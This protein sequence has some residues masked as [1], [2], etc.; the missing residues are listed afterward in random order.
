MLNFTQQ[1]Y[2]EGSR[3]DFLEQLKRGAYDD[4]VGLYRSNESAKLVTGPFDAELIDLLPSTLKFICHSGAGYDNLDVAACTRKG[5][6][7]ATASYLPFIHTMP[8]TPKPIK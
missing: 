6:M 4:V 3:T 7:P 2:R 8:L 5:Q 1:E